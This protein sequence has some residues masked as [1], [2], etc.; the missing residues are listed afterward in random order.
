MPGGSGSRCRT[1][2]VIDRVIATSRGIGALRLAGPLRLAAN[3]FRHAA[4]LADLPVGRGLASCADGPWLIFDSLACGTAAQ[5]VQ[6]T[7]PEVG[8]TTAVCV[9]E[10]V[11]PTHI[12]HSPRSLTDFNAVIVVGVSTTRALT[13]GLAFNSHMVTATSSGGS[14]RT[15]SRALMVMSH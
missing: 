2:G 1:P 9:C 8:R 11:F 4:K 13:Y 12:S 7:P 5:Q 3:E 10:R 14:T 15:S 6:P